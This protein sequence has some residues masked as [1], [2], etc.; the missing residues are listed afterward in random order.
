VKEGRPI[1]FAQMRYLTEIGAINVAGEYF[2]RGRRH[3]VLGKVIAVF[4]DFFGSFGA[5][6]TK[7]NFVAFWAEHRLRIVAGRVGQLLGNLAFKVGDVNIIGI[8]DGPKVFAASAQVWSVRASIAAFVCAGIK[9]VLAIWHEIGTGGA[10]FQCADCLWPIGAVARCVFDFHAENLVAF[11]P[12][13]LVIALERKR[14]AV[15]APIRFCIIA[16]KSELADVFEVFFGHRRG[17]M[18]ASVSRMLGKKW[19]DYNVGKKK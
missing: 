9:N 16:A 1:G 10:A 12:P 19:K 2:H 13:F 14:L 11:E 18:S 17:H 15:R 7:H 4:F 5:A 3:E 8:K 6:G